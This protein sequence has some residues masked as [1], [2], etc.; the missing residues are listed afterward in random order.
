MPT[1]TVAALIQTHIQRYP[2]SEILDVYKLL[3]QA[4]FGP[5][6]AIKNQRAAREWLDRESELYV[7]NANEALTENIHPD[8][9]IVRVHLRP[10]LA[11]RGNLKVLLD[12]FIQSS[13]TVTGDPA[14]LA[15][16]WGIFQE[17][18]AEG[19]ALAG[20]FDP[21]T[22]AL[23][24]RTR[25]SEQWPASHH[26]PLFEQTYKPAYRVLTAGIAED[27]LRQQNIPFAPI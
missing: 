14:I 7:P 9:A 18:T 21:R 2:K 5:G 6:H 26:S 12:G 24:G 10:Y 1:Q 23:I 27:I 4:I 8:G 20:L 16:S 3:H 13:K 17:M 22:V 25:A 15:A 11:A 19:G